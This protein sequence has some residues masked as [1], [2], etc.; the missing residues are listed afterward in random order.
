MADVRVI[1]DS[2]QRS[3]G[4][5]NPP[6]AIDASQL[7]ENA[8]PL[9]KRL[10]AGKQTT[11]RS[12]QF[13]K[14]QRERSILHYKVCAG[15]LSFAEYYSLS[16]LLHAKVESAVVSEEGLFCAFTLMADAATMDIVSAQLLLKQFTA[17]V[18]LTELVLWHV[19]QLYPNRDA[20]E[21]TRRLWQEN[22]KDYVNYILSRR[23]LARWGRRKIN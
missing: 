18:L 20:E 4:Q 3:E 21:Q 14:S 8:W 1:E 9:L 23:D 17:M 6:D 13:F 5:R 2:M 15:P 16:D 22:S 19:A 12:V 11:R 7:L 10:I